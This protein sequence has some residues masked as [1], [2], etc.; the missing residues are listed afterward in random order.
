MG[1]AQK[2]RVMRREGERRQSSFEDEKV[3]AGLGLGTASCQHL[4]ER[5]GQ[6]LVDGGCC[7]NLCLRQSTGDISLTT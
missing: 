5:A 1:V 2:G 3:H 4:W 7:P 6:G